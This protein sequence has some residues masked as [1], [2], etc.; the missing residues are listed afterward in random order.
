MASPFKSLLNAAL[1]LFFPEVC[2][3]CAMCRA[4]PE[5]GYVCGEC[6]DLVEPIE[7][8]FCS[9]CGLP[10]QGAIT[11]EFQ[12]FNCAGVELHFDWARSAAVARGPVLEAIHRYKYNRQMWF[13][14]FLAE[15]LIAR[16]FPSLRQDQWDAILP[17]PLHRSKRREREFNQAEHLADRLS[18]ASGIPLWSQALQRIRPTESQARLPSARRIE[19]VRGAFAVR[20]DHAIRSSRLV[21]VDDVFTT[22]CT[23]NECA[24]ALRSAGAA[25]IGVWTVVRAVSRQPVAGEEPGENS[26]AAS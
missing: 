18:K 19:N 14:V 21:L 22:G 16:A 17:V 7:E 26:A 15:L 10:F 13:E 23:T 11:H 5:Q 3:L 20:P 1:G 8:P 4:T 24:R 12:C 25:T 6:R 2:Q 9:R